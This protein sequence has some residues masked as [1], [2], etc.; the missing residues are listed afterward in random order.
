TA[1]DASLVLQALDKTADGKALLLLR[2]NDIKGDVPEELAHMRVTFLQREKGAQRDL[3]KE[4][5]TVAGAREYNWGPTS[6]YGEKQDAEPIAYAAAVATDTE[7]TN[8]HVLIDQKSRVKDIVNSCLPWVMERDG[9][10]AKL[11]ENGCYLWGD[12]IED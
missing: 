6:W 3:E 9:D 5:W 2:A 12:A 11:S 8:L 1:D 10:G 4:L 7:A